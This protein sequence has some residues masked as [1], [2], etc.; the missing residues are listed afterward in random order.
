MPLSAWLLRFAGLRLPPT[1]LV[2]LTVGTL[3]SRYIRTGTDPGTPF[4]ALR[5]DCSQ[6]C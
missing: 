5:A 4:S 2:N 1:G 6:N 3:A